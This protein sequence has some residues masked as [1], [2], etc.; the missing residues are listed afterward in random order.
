MSDRD[1]GIYR[2]VFVRIW[3]H[4]TFIG[5]ENDARL[6]FLMFMTHPKMTRLGVM[7]MALSTMCRQAKL[8]KSGLESALA[9]LEGSGWAE[10]DEENELVRLPRF[11][12]HN[13]PENP[14][15]AK[16]L[17]HIL[18]S[19]PRVDLVFRQLK[20][21]AE[22]FQNLS[23]PTSRAF[24][25][26]LP[27]WARK[28]LPNPLEKPLPDP[29]GDPSP[30]PMANR[31]EGRGIRDKGRGK[32]EEGFRRGSPED[33]EQFLDSEYSESLDSLLGLWPEPH[34]P[35]SPAAVSRVQR[36]FVLAADAAHGPHRLTE[37][38]AAYLAFCE[39]T[40][41]PVRSVLNWVKDPET[42]AEDWL[43]KAAAAAR[44]PPKS[45]DRVTA[46]FEMEQQAIR[47][48][49][50]TPEPEMSDEQRAAIAE[51]LAERQGAA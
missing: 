2:R 50:P 18:D 26:A 17:G 14:N 19:L 43:A 40:D 30:K 1:R 15:V 27:G 45:R 25:N 20:T 36:E 31:E 28:A 34:R 29:S 44:N 35:M 3:N 32:R 48:N 22:A 7:E 33:E 6:L 9:E 23:E 13:P 37:N 10:W 16:S 46:Q 51:A 11:L 8:S 42:Y 38:G 47:G 21:A 5:F 41:R 39:M 24:A 4:P 49:Q 12:E